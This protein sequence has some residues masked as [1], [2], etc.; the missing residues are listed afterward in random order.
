MEKKAVPSDHDCKGTQLYHC[1][2]AHFIL[3]SFPV[4][5]CIQIHSKHF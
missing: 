5:V 4:S 1:P 3:D 2:L